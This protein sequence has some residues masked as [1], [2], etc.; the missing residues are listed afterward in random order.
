MEDGNLALG[1]VLNMLLNM[2]I[3]LGYLQQFTKT[4]IPAPSAIRKNVL[5]NEGPVS[6]TPGSSGQCEQKLTRG[7]HINQTWFIGS[8]CWSTR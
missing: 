7:Q 1:T 8:L 4:E 6:L 2:A 3:L 5:E